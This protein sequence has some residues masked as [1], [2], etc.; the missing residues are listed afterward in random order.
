MT[1]LLDVT[2][3]AHLLLEAAREVG[4]SNP[5]EVADFA[6]RLERGLP[7][8][9]ELCVVLNW[10][11]NCSLVHKLDQF[12]YPPGAH[13]GYRV[14][15]LFAVFTLDGKQVPVFIEVKNFGQKVL[16]WKPDYLMGLER[17][18]N[19]VNIPL[20]VAWK[21]RSFW[22]LFEPRHM[23]LAKT[24]RNISFAD[25]MR[26]SLMGLL[27]GDFSFSFEPGVGFN[28]RICKTGDWTQDGPKQGVIEKAYFTR[29]DGA[30]QKAPK[31]LLQLFL[32]VDQ[33][34][35]T[36]ENETHIMQSYVIGDQSQ[37]AHRALV[38]LLGE[39][40]KEGKGEWRKVLLSNKLP[41]L[42]MGPREAVR[43]AQEAGFIR[44]VFDLQ[45][46]SHPGF[47][48]ADE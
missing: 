8:E 18:A 24:N 36:T 32:C 28:L 6:R 27:A 44:L 38:A 37:F 16:S 15:D 21:H 19:L 23:R 40:G 45:P 13:E 20:L 17:Y 1:D 33:D 12:P 42:D 47:I 7:A 31:G 26:E 30:E 25:A 46:N 3:K 22:T 29:S 11:G 48:G 5:Q 4:W 14:P 43:Q 34:A 9:D 2:A 35:R 10:L 39:F 41:L